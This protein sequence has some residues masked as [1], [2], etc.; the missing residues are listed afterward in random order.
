MKK[1]KL[2][3]IGILLAH[4][5]FVVLSMNQPFHGDEIVFSESAKAILEKGVPVFD[6]GALKLNF[7][8]LWHTP[9][10]MYIMSLFLLIF[11]K[12]IYAFRSVSAFFNFLTIILVF[13][14]SK[15]IFKNHKNRE[16]FSLFAAF[17]YALNPLTIQSSI[18]LDIDGGLLNFAI[19]L[20]LFFYIKGKRWHY[21]LPSLLFVFLSKEFGPVVLFGSILL[22]KIIS[23]DWKK[24]W[25]T[26]LM[27]IITGILFLI[28]F[29]LYTSFFNLDFFMPFKHNIPFLR[30]KSFS[31]S[32]LASLM[33]KAWS[34]K[35]FFY[36]AVPFFIGLFF[37]FTLVF[38][39]KLIKN[40]KIND[41]NILL[42]NIFAL[43]NIFL[44]FYLGASA[45]GFPKYYIIALPAMSI[46]T[47]YMLKDYA[48]N[49]K[50][51]KKSLAIFILLF[52]LLLSWFLIF[53]PSPLMPEFDA[54]SK[55]ADITNSLFLILKSFSFYVIIP[56]LIC[57]FV[58]SIAKF[59]KIWLVSL[60][61]LIFFS[62][63]YINSLHAIVN[64]STYSTYGDRG[65]LEVVDYFSDIPASSI[66]AY[67]HLGSYLGMPDFY[68]ITF[69]YNN[70][71]DFKEKIIDND[72]IIYVVIY[73]RDIDRIG[74]NMEYFILEKKIGTYYIYKKNEN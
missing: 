29:G 71:K 57:L 62:Y 20:F 72:E 6:Y 19:Y 55:N 23:K 56:T 63:F 52:L 16:F 50:L 17:L 37:I 58:F 1:E 46:F 12:G 7:Q 44:L 32:L 5:I 14:I 30:E 68:E 54:T 15:E 2:I 9:L 24:I 13:L 69:I 10:Y 11:G 35:T 41:K 27:F 42:L 48:D 34:F 36:F 64:Y 67:P 28:I 39:Y 65:V 47:V 26:F 40:Q 74:K 45:W 25:R 21:L 8:G 53:I 38:Y 49:F 73:K 51:S 60:I 3:L 4:A 18:I 59:K 31:V 66:A 22:L 70:E 61:L 33:T 43:I